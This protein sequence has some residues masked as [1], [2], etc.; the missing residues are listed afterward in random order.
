MRTLRILSSLVL[1]SL[2]SW[3]VVSLRAQALTAS[4]SQLD[5]GVVT[6]L[7]PDSLPLTLTNT[8]NRPVT[9]I[10]LR[11]YNSYG[12]PAF[13]CRYNW[14]FIP[15][16]GTATCWIRFSPRHNVYHNSELVI[17]DDGLRGPLRIDLVG[18]GRYSKSYYANTENLEEE[19][20]KNAFRTLL[21]LDYDTL[22]YVTGR[23]SMFMQIDNL[24]RNG[25]GATQNTI[26]SCY[27]GAL[28]VGYVDRTDCQNRFSFN[29]EHTFPQSFFNSLEPMRSD[30]HHLYACDDLSNNQRGNNPFG[31]VNNNI[32][33]SG[34]GSKSDGSFFEPRDAQKGKAARSLLYFVLRY[35]DYSG[36]VQPQETLLR[37]WHIAFPP[38]VTEQR[39][40]DDIFTNQRN[41]NPFIDYPQFI[42]RI[43]SVT[44]LSVAP[45]SASLDLPVDTI[46]YG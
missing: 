25:Q 1:F 29:T 31:I 10:N 19:P 38:G 35:Q 9:V 6:E 16:G 46:V 42:D 12:A 39:R 8:L 2:C 26:E 22:G 37:T 4:V 13:S 32:I 33:W 41:R 44:T 14:F 11:F 5:F 43:R 17:E 18:Q 15:A 30:L 36:F 27:T 28:A 20:L 45:L 40:N 23:D 3:P 21:A 7:S 24:A 34:G